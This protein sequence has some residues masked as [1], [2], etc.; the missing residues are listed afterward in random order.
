MERR[1][2]RSELDHCLGSN[3][4]QSLPFVVL[5]FKHGHA[6]IYRY[7]RRANTLSELAFASDFAIPVALAE[8]SDRLITD[9]YFVV[10]KLNVTQWFNENFLI[11]RC[12]LL[13]L[14]S[15]V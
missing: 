10:R 1:L 14:I 11:Y 13:C 6:F 2:L 9:V 5:Q 12:F 15:D 3:S 4:H 7:L 8:L